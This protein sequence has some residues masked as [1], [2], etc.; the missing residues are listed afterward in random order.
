MTEQEKINIRN[1]VERIT[2]ENGD[3]LCSIRSLAIL[4]YEK[5]DNQNNQEVFNE[6]ELKQLK[7]ITSVLYDIC[8]LIQSTHYQMNETTYEMI[9]DEEE[10]LY[11]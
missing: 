5:A 3:I 11:L 8:D 9:R 7:E 4:A 1:E 6:K 10:T 2:R